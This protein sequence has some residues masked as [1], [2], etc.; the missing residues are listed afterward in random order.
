MSS[1]TLTLDP[2]T[3]SQFVGSDGGFQVDVPT[4]AVTS[5][6]VALAG[7]RLGLLIRQIA[8]ASGSSAGGSGHVSLGT[9]LL[10]VVDAGGKLATVGLRQPATLSF[11]LGSHERALDWRYGYVVLNGSVPE[12]AILNPDPAGAAF[13]ATDAHLGAMSSQPL[14][15]V[16]SQPTVQTM[17]S[18][19]SPSTSASFNT[20][21]PIASFGRPDPFNVD[22]SAGSLMASY[23]IDVPAGPGGLTPPLNLTYSS[24]SVAEQHSPQAAAPWV[25]EGWN[26]SLGSISWAEHNVASGCQALGTCTLPTW[27][28]SWQINDAYGTAAEL[29]PPNIGVTTSKD[30]RNGAITPSPL[31]WHTAPESHAKVISY[32]PSTVASDPAAVSWGTNRV[33]TFIRGSDGALWHRWWDSVNWSAW[34]SLG[35]TILG[36]PAAVSWGPNRLDVFAQGTDNALWHDW[37]DGSWHWESL[38]GSL[39]SGPAAVTLGSGRLD[40]FIRGSADNVL[41]HKGYDSST[42]RAWE[43]V[44]GVLASDPTAI[45]GTANRL[46]VFMRGSD[47][48]L[49]HAFGTTGAWQWE[50]LLGTLQSRPAA[51]SWA[52]NRMDVFIRGAGDNALW[53]IFWNGT[54]WSAWENLAGVLNS[55]PSVAAWS[56]NRLDLFM[57]GT[58]NA[59]WHQWWNGTSW[60]TWESLVGN[61]GSGPVAST[62]GSGHLDVFARGADN[63]L[64]HDAYDNGWHAW[65]ALGSP[66]FPCFRVFLRNAIME[67]FGCTTDSIQFYPTTLGSSGPDY[68]ANW[69]LDL[70]TDPHGNQIHITYQADSISAGGFTYPRDVVLS[71]VEYDSPGCRNAQVTCTGSTWTPLMRVNF[72][73]SHSVGHVA[74]SS[75]PPIQ[76][77]RCDAPV[78]LAASGGLAN[79]MVQSTFVLNDVQVQVRANGS[80]AWNTVRDY[81]LGYDQ[82]T[83]VTKPDP[84]TGKNESTAGRLNLTQMIEIGADGSTVLPTRSFAY[85][86]VTEYYEDDAWHPTPSTACGPSWN[87]GTGSGCLLWSPSYEGNSYYLASVSNGLGLQQTFSWANARNNTWGVNQGSTLN[88]LACTTQSQFPCNEADDQNWSHVVLTQEAG[89]VVRASQNGQGGAQTNTPVTTTTSYTYQLSSFT[90]QP[91]T[92]CAQG[93]Y[94]GNQKDG[95]YLDYYNGKFTG[96][97]QTMLVKPDGAVELHKYYSSAGFGVYDCSQLSCSGSGS[98]CANPCHTDP[99]WQIG[100]AGHGHEFEADFYDTNGSTLLRQTKSQYALTCPP[101]GV[102]GSP[103]AGWGNWNGNLVSELDPSN[104]VGVCDIQTSQVDDYA[105]DGSTNPAV[106]HRTT[107][108]SYDSYGRVTSETL[109]ANDGAGTGSASTIVHKPAYATND[110]VTANATSATGSYLINFEAFSDDEDASG[111]RYRCTYTSYDGASTG[112]TVGDVTRTDQYTNCG[113]PT[114]FNDRSGPLTTTHTYDS[115]GNPQTTNDPDANAGDAAHLGCAVGGPTLYSD[116]TTYDSTFSV[117]PVSHSNALNQTTSTTHQSPGSATAAYGFGLWPVSATDANNQTTSFGYDGLGRPTSQV[118]PGDT[119]ST[120][121]VTFTYTSW[122][123]GTA[124]QPPCLEIDQTR[125]LNTTTTVTSRAF[126]DG[127]GNLVATRVPAPN[128]QDVVRYA[129]YDP[130]IR[131]VSQ[132]VAYFVAAYTGGPGAAA[133]LLPDS[134]QPATNHTYDGLGRLLTSIDPLS[135]RTTNTITVACNAAGT[136]DTGCYEQTLTVDPLGHQGG[137]LVDALGR[138]QYLQRFTGNSPATSAL[139]ATTR[140]TYDVSGNLTQVLHPDGT[141]RTTFAYDMA[142]RKT[143]MTDPD[144]G[145]ITH[146]YDQNGNAWQSVDAR[147]GAGTVYARYDGL[148]RPLWRNSTNVPTGAYQTF[149]YDSTAGGNKGTGRL[150]SE[151]F[152]GGPSNTLSGSYGYVYDARG[153]QTSATLTVGATSYPVQ[154]TFDDAGNTLTQTYPTGEVVT[155]SYTAQGWLSSLA[156]TQ[157]NTSLLSSAAY[158]GF[159]G[160]AQQLTA[161]S[162][163][164]GRYQYSATFDALLRPSDL[165]LAN[166]STVLFEQARTFDGAGN[167]TSANTTLPAGTD[168]QAFC[169]DE[170]DRLTW[171]GATGTPPCGVSLTSGSLTSA[172]Y[173]HTFSYD[174]LGRLTSGPTGSYTYGTSAHLHGATAIG[175]VYTAAYDAAGGMTCRAPTSATTCAGT[176]TGA[177]LSYDNEG[178]LAAWQNTPSNPTTT[179]GFLYDNQGSRVEQQATQNGTTTTTIY[180]GNLE[181]VATTGSTTTTTTFYYAGSARIALAVNGIVS[182]LAADGLA[183]ATVAL[184]ANGNATASSLYAP[185]GTARYSSGTMPTDYGFTGQHADSATGLDYYNARYYDPLAGQFASADTILPGDGY[186]IFGLS[187]YAYVEGNPTTRTDPSGRCPW[188]IAAVVG[189]LIGGGLSYGTQVVGNLQRG[190]SLGSALTHVDVGEIGKQMLVGFVIGGTGGLG[191]A[192][193]G[194]RFVLGGVQGGASQ[195][196]DNLLHGRSWSQDVLQSTGIGLA[197]AGLSAGGGA[198]LRRVFNRAGAG[199]IADGQ[200]AVNGS[201]TARMSGA[202][203]PG[204]GLGPGG[205]SVDDPAFSPRPGEG[206]QPMTESA[207]RRA[208]FH[209]YRV[210]TSEANNFSTEHQWGRNPNLMGPNG[211][212]GEVLRATDLNGTQVF[213]RNHRWGHVFDDTGET[214]GPHY[215]GPKDEHYFYRSRE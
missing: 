86:P 197:T 39:R 144:L 177:Q 85:T 29:I 61:L 210:K 76:S 206:L 116:C 185:Y 47:N 143:G 82:G 105:I 118:L 204:S 62:W 203:G 40:V 170:Q 110:S 182:Y 65:D 184:D 57:R 49:W 208:A 72:A 187:R 69:L 98:Y 32:A 84:L 53:H 106:P 46:D 166:G 101:T 169:Y 120:P 183:S 161:A 119:S 87:T 92:G 34:E 213:I 51:A 192:A 45:S 164:G 54:S 117:L 178:S 186:D 140:Y 150:T 109:A 19:S 8:P 123:S 97:A 198:A 77:L 16:L 115:F 27:N 89:T 58:D 157:G 93:F 159:G 63:G 165:K 67:E 162:L 24:A 132:S 73:A 181:Q 104:P 56:A 195:I 21:S 35:G 20:N 142:G 122:C 151:T 136:G 160:A 125:R 99:W 33:D 175:S 90:A 188:C 163:G 10:Q 180:V 70:I 108:Y 4:G 148:N 1:A 200:D 94:W 174:N 59:L 215:L 209:A 18:L 171:A 121:T 114:T 190:Q 43:S 42:W 194:G 191:G 5:S 196:G 48:A 153:Q 179:A 2:N 37:Y 193:L 64:W 13:S 212:P 9:F 75:C 147:A 50:S 155:T 172:R 107:T 68:V 201:V 149:S 189:G 23:P 78:N 111:N 22:L 36:T 113:T 127:R 141:S 134:T 3:A 129:Y 167:L 52:A 96:F 88:P 41:W 31:T 79:P 44:G 81:Q 139:Y 126:Y 91:C 100:N 71:S 28:D 55:D 7:G 14:T 156:T 6:D 26:L 146:T 130:S 158:S 11:H 135:Q 95:D 30:S 152:T 145:T 25:G 124:A 207:A 211:E 83:Q 15:A 38:G 102:A 80:A 17:A 168:N 176:A 60:N 154:N 112:V 133:Y 202:R 138:K 12:G 173:T 205:A 103:A 74:G 131:L 137:G 66:S 199:V 128:N 214:M